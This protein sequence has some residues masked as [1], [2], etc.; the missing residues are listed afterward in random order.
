MVIAIFRSKLRAD[1]GAEYRPLAI[2]MLK[3][4]RSMP[5]FVSFDSYSAKDGERVS[6]VEFES[7]AAL[8]AWRD[9][10]EHQDAQRA[11]RDRFYSE[12][13]V[14]VCRPLRDYS[15]DGEERHEEVAAPDR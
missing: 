13:R 5:G 11:G 12:Y 9:Q 4:A 8:E 3:L 10:P 2:R 14:Q 1:A 6:I 15:F 7:E